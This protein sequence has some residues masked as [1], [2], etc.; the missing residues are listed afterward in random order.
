MAYKRLRDRLQPFKQ[1]AIAEACGARP[2]TVHE[3]YH[4]RTFPAPE[5][6]APLAA[7]LGI[8]VEE[9]AEVIAAEQKERAIA[10][11]SEVA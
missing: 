5:Y 3:W 8:S 7:L 9:L 6:Y 2:A 11:A 1:T 10:R 4:G